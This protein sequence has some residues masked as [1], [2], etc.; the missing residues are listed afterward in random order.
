MTF[1]PASIALACTMVLVASVGSTSA[2]TTKRSIGV[3][4][5]TPPQRSVP[6]QGQCVDPRPGNPGIPCWDGGCGQCGFEG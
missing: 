3:R 2:E 1:H 4:H 5:Y 6:Q